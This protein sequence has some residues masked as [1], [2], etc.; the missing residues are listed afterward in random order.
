MKFLITPLLLLTLCARAQY[1]DSTHYYAG[2]NA[3][4][5]VN[6]T[7]D[8]SSYILNNSLR[9]GIR[10]KNFSLNSSNSWMYGDQQNKLTNNDFTSTL[11]FDLRSGTPHFYYWGLANYISSYS[12]KINNQYQG[13]AGIAYNIFDRDSLK[14]N[15]SDGILYEQSDVYLQDTVR[16]IYST[17]RNSL[18]LRLKWAFRNI[19]TFNGM[20][21]YQNSLSSGTDYIV[22]VDA[23]LAVKL[24]KWLSLTTAF[25]YNR[26]SRTEKENTL[27]TYGLSVERYF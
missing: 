12:L 18:R 24:Y 21:F 16:D 25:T 13:G 19:V 1:N 20:A 10:K 15:I 6:N 23:G 2:L 14:L 8:G 17:F 3:T 5:T 26:F 7:N 22:K 9:L 27:F 11:D 4:G